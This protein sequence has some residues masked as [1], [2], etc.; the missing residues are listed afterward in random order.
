MFYLY[1][2]NITFNNLNPKSN[3]GERN[4]RIFSKHNEIV[5]A[6]FTVDF[7]LDDLENS[8]KVKLLN[9]LTETEKKK[10][11]LIKLTITSKFSLNSKYLIM[12]TIRKEQVD[13]PVNTTKRTSR[14]CLNSKFY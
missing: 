2:S 5:S 14:F 13:N 9:I 10:K 11:N 12:L 6:I 7:P 8:S 1:F 3:I 4:I